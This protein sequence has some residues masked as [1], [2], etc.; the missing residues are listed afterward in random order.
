ML[1]EFRPALV[2][3]AAFTLLTG[4]AYPA[5]VTAR[6]ARALSAAGGGQPDPRRRRRYAA[7]HS[8]GS[9]SVA[10]ATSGAGRR[11]RG[12]PTTP[13]RRPAPT[14]GPPT[15]RWPRRWPIASA[16]LRAADPVEH[17]TGAGRPRHRLGQ[18]T[19]SAHHAGGG[20]ISG[21]A[22]GA[23]PQP[24]RGTGPAARCRAHRG[25]HLR[26]SRR[27][28]RQCAPAQPG[29]R[30]G[31]G[32]RSILTP[33]CRRRAIILQGMTD[34]R[35]P[36]PDALLAL[37]REEE[38]R[39]HR[40]RLKLFFGAAPG[41]GKTY[42]MLEAARARQAEGVDVRG[43]RGRDP[44]P[45]RDRPPHRGPHR[46]SPPYHRLQGQRAGGVRP[47]RRAGAEAGAHPHGRAG[48]HQRARRPARQALAGRARAARCRHRCL[49]HAQRAARREPQRRG[50]ADH[51]RHRARDGAGCACS[52]A[53]TRSSWSTSRPTF[54]C[55]G[56]ARGGCTCPTR[57]AAPSSGSSARA[58]SSPSANW[59]C[60]RR[61]T[62]S[63][64]RCAATCGARG[65]AIP[66]PRATAWRC[67][68]V[69]IPRRRGSFARRA[70]WRNDCRRQ[71]TAVFVEVPGQVGEDAREAVVR[72]FR[73]AEELGGE[74]ITLSGASVA[75][76]IMAWAQERNVTRL[77]V[78]KPQRRGLRARLR[79]SLLDALVERSGS[80]DVFVI[81]GEA[82]DTAAAGAVPASAAARRS[83]P[84][85]PASS[86]WPRRLGLPS[87]RC[88][89]PPTWRCCTCWRRWS[90]GRACGSARRSSP[91]CSASPL[92]D[93]CFVPPYYTFAVHDVTYMLTFAMMLAIAIIM[94]R[95]TG[96]IREQADASRAREQRT[97]SAFA[98]SREMT[99]AREP[100]EIAAAATR[101][102]EDAFAGRV[103]FLLRTTTARSGATASRAGPSTT[104]RWPASARAHFPPRPRSTFRCRP[105]TGY[106]AWCGSSRA[107]RG[108]SSI[109]NAGS[110]SSPS[111]ARPRWRSSAPRSP[112]ATRPAAWKWRRSAS[113]PAC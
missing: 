105:R 104:G 16:A 14:S 86:P 50:G 10:P 5:A 9:R 52:S 98:L 76:E 107:I 64:P 67:A 15:R 110:S 39:Q 43:R 22:S 35:R 77:I 26:R 28:T 6:G 61:R 25:S 66:G 33:P 70:A 44:R 8:S 49:H 85:L 82:D 69:P 97:A 7:R 99:A 56:C 31:E 47:R 95:L 41:V 96:R 12:Q 89:A 1:A 79:G 4:V 59:R 102:I 100:P 83:M 42:T 57:R 60:G 54:C 27:T 90:S 112:S 36:D 32:R 38:A 13:P 51:R 24:V 21:R 40:G 88:S 34:P 11:P 109:R 53:P 63:T 17:G 87:G 103:V 23:C 29:A 81:T 65:S 71:W 74:T 106:S 78:G 91:R 113:A 58:T 80:I 84:G 72:A 101:H 45:Q 48:P 19:R 37:V 93:F 20:G 111:C 94:S 68:S 75:D 3:L 46:S 30:R 108:M 73:L 55:S 2:L 62:G 92:F 18:R